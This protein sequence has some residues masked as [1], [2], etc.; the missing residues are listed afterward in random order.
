MQKRVFVIYINVNIS[1]K[2]SSV[3][4][5]EDFYFDEKEILYMMGCTFTAIK[6]KCTHKPATNML[7]FLHPQSNCSVI[8]REIT[9]LL[10]WL[11]FKDLRLI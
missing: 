4:F 9:H 6:T 10:S 5:I 1:A 11:Y 3:L 8:K 7:F 2:N